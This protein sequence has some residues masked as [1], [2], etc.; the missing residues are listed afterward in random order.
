[1]RS[2]NEITNLE[3]ERDRKKKRATGEETDRAQDRKWT[4]P[5]GS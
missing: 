3:K 2:K 1:M 5:I 4:E